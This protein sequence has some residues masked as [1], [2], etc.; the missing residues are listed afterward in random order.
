MPSTLPPANQ[1]PWTP[2][3]QNQQAVTCSL[4]RRAQTLIGLTIL[5]WSQF[6]PLTLFIP[7]CLHAYSHPSACFR[8]MGPL[9][10]AY[11]GAYSRGIA[12]KGIRITRHGDSF[13]AFL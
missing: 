1:L 2:L 13:E 8:R 6:A 12:S 11:L 7:S 3:Q 5:S 4:I 9:L 10:S